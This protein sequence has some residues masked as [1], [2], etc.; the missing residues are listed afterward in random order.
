MGGEGRRDRKKKNSSSAASFAWG[1]EADLENVGRVLISSPLLHRLS[2]LFPR[3]VDVLLCVSACAHVRFL[4]DG[5]KMN[6]FPR[7]DKLI[8]K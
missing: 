8:N 2:H 5:K 3:R 4:T 6:G 7:F 1:V